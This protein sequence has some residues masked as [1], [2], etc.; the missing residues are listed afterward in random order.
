[1]E[2][3]NHYG[4]NA[5][6]RPAILET[7]IEVLSAKKSKKT[8]DDDG[9]RKVNNLQTHNF[10]YGE[11][12]SKTIESSET[13]DLHK[14]GSIKNNSKAALQNDKEDKVEEDEIEKDEYN[15]LS[16]EEFYDNYGSPGHIKSITLK[17]FMCHDYFHF[18]FKPRIN[19]LNGA[20]GSKFFMIN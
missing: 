3:N 1:M 15:S 5:L 12:S 8:D 16:N 7:I 9:F 4:T 2:Q 20:S 13:N 11:G 14:F 17:N 6:K 10:H 19:I 18:D